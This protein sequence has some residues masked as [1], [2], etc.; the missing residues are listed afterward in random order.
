MFLR[1]QRNL[2]RTYLLLVESYRAQG[3]VKQRVLFR[4]GRLDQLRA[5]G[6]LDGLLLALG[7]FSEKF[8]VLGAHAEGQRVSSHAR[9]IGAAL[10]FERLWRGGGGRGRRRAGA[11]HPLRVDRR[12]AL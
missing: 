1:T 6:E 2:N 9:S 7:R 5:S 4:L 10:I 11:S 8:A 12:A 3:R